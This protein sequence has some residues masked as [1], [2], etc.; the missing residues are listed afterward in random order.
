MAY[1]RADFVRVNGYDEAFVGWGREDTDLVVRM[2]RSG[3]TRRLL[4]LAGVG[5]HLH[6]REKSRDDLARNDALL[7]AALHAGPVR[8]AKGVAQ[9]L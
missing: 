6:H 8:C 1:W 4:K 7:A 5:Y 2:L 3:A 9:Y